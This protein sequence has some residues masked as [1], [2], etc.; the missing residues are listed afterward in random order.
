MLPL[1][2]LL[3]EAAYFSSLLNFQTWQGVGVGYGQRQE[4]GQAEHY[5]SS[6]WQIA[7]HYSIRLKKIWSFEPNDVYTLPSNNFLVSSPPPGFG[8]FLCI[9]ILAVILNDFCTDGTTFL[10][11]PQLKCVNA[12]HHHSSIMKN[13][14]ITPNCSTM[15]LINS[16][17]TFSEQKPLYFQSSHSLNSHYFHSGHMETYSLFIAHNIVSYHTKDSQIITEWIR[18]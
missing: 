15:E 18:S 9:L 13:P 1:Q 17:I 8:T 12:L 6:V 11:L 10:W 14:L 2:N 5:F 7:G 4:G 3:N 16:I